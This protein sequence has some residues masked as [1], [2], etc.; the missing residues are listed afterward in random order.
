[1]FKK[2]KKIP[3]KQASIFVFKTIFICVRNKI[4]HRHKG[5]LASL[6]S[7]L[8]RMMGSNPGLLQGLHRMCMAAM[9]PPL[10]VEEGHQGFQGKNVPNGSP[11]TAS[12]FRTHTQRRQLAIAVARIMMLCRGPTLTALARSGEMRTPGLSLYAQAVKVR[13]SDHWANSRRFKVFYCIVAGDMV[14][15]DD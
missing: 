11:P 13:H 12:L 7:N 8:C 10:C 14:L 2:Y 9:H 6:G 4:D 15:L 1:L 5:N 3:I